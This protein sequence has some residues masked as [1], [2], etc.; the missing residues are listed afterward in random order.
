[1]TSHHPDR[2]GIALLFEPH[3]RPTVHDIAGLLTRKSGTGAVSISHRPDPRDG[4]VELLCRGLTFD[5]AGLAPGQGEPLPDV[6]HGY[7]LPDAGATLQSEA[8]TISVGQ[9]LGGGAH[10]LPVVCAQ[11][12]VALALMHLPGLCAVV[13]RPAAIAMSPAYFSLMASPWVNGGPF[14]ALGLTRLIHAA[15]DTVVSQGLSFFTGQELSLA[16]MPGQGE[17]E[18]DKLAIRLIHK[19]VESGPIT[20]PCEIIGPE[21]EAFAIEPTEDGRRLRVRGNVLA[22]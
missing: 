3:A 1:M 15:D 8:M 18:M 6:G 4:W 19:L 16:A 5:L 13:W 17:A 10:L 22:D 20:A 11:M 12:E 14:P 7:G 21:G 2:A 9:H